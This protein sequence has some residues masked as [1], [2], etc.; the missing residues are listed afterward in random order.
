MPKISTT[1]IQQFQQMA[2]T[3]FDLLVR[4]NGQATPHLAW[5]TENGLSVRHQ[6]KLSP[7]VAI[8]GWGKNALKLLNQ[9]WV[10]SI[11]LDGS[12]NVCQPNKR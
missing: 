2:D 1:L 12:V 11:E 4:T 7:G 8:T 6:F 10:V 5:L 3:T 9:S